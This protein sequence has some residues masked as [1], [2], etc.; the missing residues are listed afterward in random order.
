M[1]EL[2][3]NHLLDFCKKTIS[4]PFTDKSHIFLMEGR[5]AL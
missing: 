4:S 1:P 3:T 5:I 2:F